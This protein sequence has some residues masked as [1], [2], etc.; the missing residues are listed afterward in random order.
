MQLRRGRAQIPIADDV[1]ALEHAARLVSGELHRHTLWHS[2]AHHR[3]HRRAAQIVGDASRTP[4]GH[5]RRLPRLGELCECAWASTVLCPL[6]DH[7]PKHPALDLSCFLELHVRGVL[8]LEQT[9]EIIGHRENPAFAVLRRPGSSRISPAAR[10][11]ECEERASRLPFS[12]RLA[13]VA[14]DQRRTHVTRS[15]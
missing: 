5:T 4:G 9:A 7:A 8:S 3:A 15:D 14:F 13:F 10:F 2:A 12:R 1:V 6:R 11:V